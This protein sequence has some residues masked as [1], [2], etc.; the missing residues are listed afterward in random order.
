MMDNTQ[1]QE[2]TYRTTN[3][4][5]Q[6]PVAKFVDF[7]SKQYYEEKDN[8]TMELIRRAVGEFTN[9]SQVGIMASV[10]SHK[11]QK[12][13]KAL[14]NEQYVAYTSAGERMFSV[15]MISGDDLDLKD[16]RKMPIHNLHLVKRAS[17]RAYLY[18]HSIKSLDGVS[19]EVDV[20]EIQFV[21]IY[22]Q[23]R[24]LVGS[25]SSRCSFFAQYDP[26]Q[27]NYCILGRPLDQDQKSQDRFQILIILHIPP[28]MTDGQ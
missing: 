7:L 14:M 24:N 21:S 10:F 20:G 17:E 19:L 8:E 12:D 9:D 4:V 2:F 13:E 6:A 16:F 1:E 18:T 27:E 5:P 3:Y 23:L 28:V 26:H 22:H 15:S 11:R 25:L